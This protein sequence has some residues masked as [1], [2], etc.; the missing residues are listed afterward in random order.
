[1]APVLYVVKPEPGDLIEID[2]GFYQHWA[3]YV[4]EGFVAN[5]ASPFGRRGG[6]SSSVRSL[7]ADRAVVK[8]E[9]LWVVVGD[10]QWRINNGLDKM[11]QP[12][13]SH[14]IVKAAGELVGQQ[15]PYCVLRDNCEHFVNNL[16]YGIAVSLQV[17]KAKLLALAS[18][19]A[20]S[21]LFGIVSGAGALCMI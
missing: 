3:V 9:E 15:R 10:N 12:R 14:I 16:R 8:R 19:L 17:L 18:L 7:V 11:Y 4:G 20:T 21:L 2:R 1:M 5:L 6:Q 13:P